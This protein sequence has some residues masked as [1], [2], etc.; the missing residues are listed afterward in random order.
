MMDLLR[1]LCRC[2]EC[3]LQD[4]GLVQQDDIDLGRAEWDVFKAEREYTAA[5]GDNTNSEEAVLRKKRA[6]A[7]YRW[8]SQML[9]IEQ[10]KWIDAEI[11]L[12]T[13]IYGPA[14]KTHFEGCRATAPP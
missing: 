10:N 1:T 2:Y 12:A 7:R 11:E 8:T 3:L 9:A 13:R 4:L 14:V 5:F 6:K